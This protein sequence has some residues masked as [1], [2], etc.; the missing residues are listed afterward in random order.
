MSELRSAARNHLKA[1]VECAEALKRIMAI[2]ERYAECDDTSNECIDMAASVGDEA[3]RAL[4][5]LE[6]IPE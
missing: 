1:L 4:A 6:A 3:R 5:A 2:A